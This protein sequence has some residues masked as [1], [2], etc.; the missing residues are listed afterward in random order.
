MKEFVITRMSGL[1]PGSFRG[2]TLI[3]ISAL[4]ADGFAACLKP[5]VYF[6]PIS[7]RDSYNQCSD[8]KKQTLKIVDE[9]EGETYNRKFCPNFIADFKLQGTA[10]VILNDTKRVINVGH[11]GSV[12]LVPK[13]VCP[14]GYGVA[15][16]CLIPYVT[17]AADLGSPYN[18]KDVIFVKAIRGTIVPDPFD[19]S[20]DWTHDGYLVIADTGGSINGSNRFDFYVGTANWRSATFPWRQDH[21]MDVNPRMGKFSITDK[22]ECKMDFEKVSGSEKERVLDRYHS[23]LYQN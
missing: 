18:A 21:L 17:I 3:L 8:S 2:L 10:T 19:S 15:N 9:E 12:Q 16:L 4:M 11:G 5:T 14:F 6:K 20:K 23:L 13:G 7:S 1:N 22:R